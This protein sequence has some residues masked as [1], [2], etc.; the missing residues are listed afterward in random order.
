[1]PPEIT[2]HHSPPAH[3]YHVRFRHHSIAHYKGDVIRIEDVSPLKVGVEKR[4]NQME[5]ADRVRADS[6]ADQV[7]TDNDEDEA[8][9][10]RINRKTQD[11]HAIAGQVP[12]VSWSRLPGADSVT[13]LA[14]MNLYILSLDKSRS[15]IQV[16]VVSVSPKMLSCTC[17]RIPD[18]TLALSGKDM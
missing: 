5:E 3:P 12:R 1:M 13:L 14:I 7:M 16:P 10:R 2:A 8:A 4:S 15:Q 9:E 11:A 6:H 18:I 17:M